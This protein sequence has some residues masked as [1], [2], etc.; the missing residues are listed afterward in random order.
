MVKMQQEHPNESFCFGV[1]AP[2]AK[3]EVSEMTSE[4]QNVDNL[5]RFVGNMDGFQRQSSVFG[6]TTILS[7]DLIDEEIKN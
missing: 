2:K 4:A 3:S 1:Y 7:T 5:N 6:G